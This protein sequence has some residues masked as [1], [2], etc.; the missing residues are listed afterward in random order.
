MKM[1]NIPDFKKSFEYENNFYLSCNNSRIGKFIAHYEL[2]K[3]SSLVPGSIVECGI[4][5]GS[6]L[7]RFAT[8]RELFKKSNKKRIIGFDSFGIFPETK[9]LKDVRFRLKFIQQAGK[10]SISEKQLKKILKLKGLEK[11]IEFVKGDITKTL[12]KY[13]KSHPK[14]KISLLNLDTDI[15]EPAVT[16]LEQLYPKIVKG[17]ILIIDDYRVTLGE[18]KAVNEYF[19]GKDIKISKFSYSKTPHFIVKN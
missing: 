11:N 12:P 18:T 5:K 4:F 6:S 1:I 17:G 16:I 8:F 7:I 10:N 9:F 19:K 2:F 13:V 14:L 3:K 15:Y